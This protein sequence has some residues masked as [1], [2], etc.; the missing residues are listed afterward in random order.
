MQT[1]IWKSLIG[2]C[3]HVF[4]GADRLLPC[5]EGTECKARQQKFESNNT[6]VRKRALGWQE[7]SS[8]YCNTVVCTRVWGMS[9]S[10]MWMYTDSR[11]HI[12]YRWN[13]LLG[14]TFILEFL[15]YIFFKIST[16]FMF[17]CSN[18]TITMCINSLNISYVVCLCACMYLG[19]CIYVKEDS[20]RQIGTMKFLFSSV[21]GLCSP[22]WHST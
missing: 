14:R 7:K 12:Y 3:L 1:S 20:E 13:W 19:E 22:S 21:G 9:R 11:E 5:F 16:L 18:P 15:F 8:Y 10:I 2:L 6:D 17:S 4:A